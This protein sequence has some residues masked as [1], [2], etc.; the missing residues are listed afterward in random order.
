MD[1]DND[2]DVNRLEVASWLNRNLY[3]ICRPFRDSVLKDLEKKALK[4]YHPLFLFLDADDNKIIN[5]TDVSTLV[6]EL[7]SNNDQKVSK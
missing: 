2:V 1:L 7:D 3:I 4:F 5:K 6:T